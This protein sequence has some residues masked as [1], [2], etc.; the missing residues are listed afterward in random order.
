[1]RGRQPVHTAELAQ[2][3]LAQLS[4]GRSLRAVCRDEG[5]PALNTVLKWVRDDREGF[6]ARYRQALRIGNA[7]RGRPSLYTDEIADRILVELLDGRRICDICAD[8]GMPS[9]AAVKL[10]V[11]EDRNGFAARYRRIRDIGEVGMGR[12]T[13][14]S[15][16]LA[17]LILDELSRGRT[18]R[19]VCRDPGMPSDNTVRV[20]VIEDREDFAALYALAREEG[21][22]AMAYKTL[23]IVDNRRHDWIP[24]VK[25]NGEIEMILDPQRVRR[26]ELRVNTR[27]VLLSKG[28][29]R[30]YGARP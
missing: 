30:K 18:L 15:P 26:A 23:D 14:Y 10:W 9:A 16:E 5:M 1:M 24:H 19:D 6:A 21:D 25:P 7:P 29:R 22:Y 20:W 28:M 2:H 3:I 4:S 17:D 13:L 12:P 11:M 8:P 27:W